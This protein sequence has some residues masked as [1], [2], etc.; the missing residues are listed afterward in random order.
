MIPFF[1]LEIDE[2]T[3]GMDFMGLV[4]YP[5]HSKSWVT[6]SKKDVKPVKYK[7]N[8]EQRIVTGVGIAVDLPIYRYDEQFGEHWIIFKK[9]ETQKI[10]EKMMANGYQNQVNEMHDLNRTL[11]GITFLESW[12]WDSQ[13]GKTDSFFANQNIKDGSWIVSYKVHDEQTWQKIKS[14]EWAGFSIEGWFNKVPLKVKGQFNNQKKPNTMKGKLWKLLFG[15]AMAFESAMT[16]DGIEVFW[17][18]ELSEGSEITIM[19]EAG[20]RVLAP[21]GEHAIQNEDGSTTVIVVDANGIATS[22][23]TVTGAEDL[24]EEEDESLSAEDIAEVIE[25][26]MGRLEKKIEEKF[27]EISTSSE[28]AN[29]ELKKDLEGKLEVLAK[30]LDEMFDDKGNSQKFNRKEKKSW[31]DYSK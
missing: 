21:E 5:A 27:N 17:E 12:F 1:T 10:V 7:F 4:D 9:K 28:T 11:S 25:E 29:V 19:D 2:N 30:E 20:E 24:E 6:L 15:T 18:G 22:I 31:K 13:R 14:G 26:A 23:E 16:T 8:E 3:E